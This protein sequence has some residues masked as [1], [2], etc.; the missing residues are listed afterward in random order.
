MWRDLQA[1]LDARQWADVGSRLLPPEL[2]CALGRSAEDPWSPQVRRYRK[3]P[4]GLSSTMRHARISSL[5][6][7]A[8]AADH[9]AH[10]TI[11]R[12]IH[13]V[14]SRTPGAADLSTVPLPSHVGPQFRGQ[15]SLIVANQRGAPS[16]RRPQF[17]ARPRHA[18]LARALSFVA[19]SRA[20]AGNGRSRALS[21]AW[22]PPISMKMCR[23]PSP[24]VVLP[25]A[26]VCVSG[27]AV[28]RNG[29]TCYCHAPA[30]AWGV[31]MGWRWCISGGQT[32]PA[33]P[34]QAWAAR[35]QAEMMASM[36]ANW[37]AP[38]K[39]KSPVCQSTLN[40]M[41]WKRP[42]GCVPM[43][44]G[45]RLLCRRPEN[46]IWPNSAG[47]CRCLR[48]RS[49]RPRWWLPLS[50]DIHPASQRLSFPVM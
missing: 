6:D 3:L 14:S 21:T 20:L 35:K 39:F 48:E 19:A 32:I 12:R 29:G 34:R 22:R 43:S 1:E 10:L 31:R 26:A 8:P 18:G 44:L 15:W 38:C 11:L 37:P 41:G 2:D 50:P 9:V 45:R 36:D 49:C 40:S 5:R 24:I 7:H 28:S 23:V 4:R 33:R 13:P 42:S 46:E 27:G 25:M 16:R 17:L 30:D 47:H